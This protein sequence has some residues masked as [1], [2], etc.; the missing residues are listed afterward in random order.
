MVE[1]H[2]PVVMCMQGIFSIVQQVVEVAYLSFTPPCI[3]HNTNSGML[4]QVSD[5]TIEDIH[6]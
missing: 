6:V 5:D 3:I 4:I 2:I 1:V